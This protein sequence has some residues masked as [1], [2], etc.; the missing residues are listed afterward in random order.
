[1]AVT[2]SDVKKLAE[3]IATLQTDM[4]QVGT[5]VERLDVTIEK[6]TEVSTHVSNLLAVQGTRLEIQ[7]KAATQL[8]ELVERRRVENDTNIKD[9]YI[10]V[11][12][13]EKDLYDE[14]ESSQNKVLAEIKEMR[15]ESTS[16]HNELT[17]KVNRLEKWMWTMVGGIA[18][19]SFL[20][21]IGI[22]FVQ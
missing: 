19:V 3:T 6:L 21:Q 9:V 17:K 16:Q 22:K 10:R 4:A 18:V 20:I 11:E 7:E 13:V 1:M 14:I 2:N 12:K 15:T 5:L 8:Q